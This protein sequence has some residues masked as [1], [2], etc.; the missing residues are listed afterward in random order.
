MNNIVEH[1]IFISSCYNTY[2]KHIDNNLLTDFITKLEKTDPTNAR[3][4]KGGW[5]SLP[6]HE[7]QVDNAITLELFN[8]TI[9]PMAQKIVNSWT[10]PKELSNYSYWYNVNRRSN[11]NQSHYHPGALLSG[12]I[13]LKVPLHSGNIVFIRSSN[14]ADRMDFIT[15]YQLTNDIICPDNP[16]INVLHWE[17]PQE[18]LLII[19][20][21]H[22]QHQV[23][24]NIST[25]EDD[26]RISLSF[27][28]FL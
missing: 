18:N 17:V 21:G 4:N 5:Q 10:L 26:A 23:D 8:T 13:Y 12:V 9:I 2:L 15:E 28:Y 20:P 3:S 27:N 22:L 25:D 6:I 19:F 14:E 1:P 11:Y 7:T 24:Q 16:N